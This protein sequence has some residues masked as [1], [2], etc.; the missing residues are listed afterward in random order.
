MTLAEEKLFHTSPLQDSRKKKGLILLLL[1]LLD[2][3]H[4]FAEQQRQYI[5]VA[6]VY[7][8]YPLESVRE[9]WEARWSSS[10]R[11]WRRQKTRL[12]LRVRTCPHESIASNTFFS[13]FSQKAY[14]C[15]V[16]QQELCST[17]VESVDLGT[18]IV[19][20]L[21]HTLVLYTDRNADH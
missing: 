5:A 7:C 14:T 11:W 17:T 8:K 18:L 9:E 1:R 15:N 19:V 20:Y 4:I 16:E 12:L 2:R 3:D 13:V 10:S 21:L 6:R